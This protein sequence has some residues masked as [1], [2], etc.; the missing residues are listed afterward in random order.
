MGAKKDSIIYSNSVKNE[1][2]L[3]WAYKQGVELTTA[4]SIA[5]LYKIKKYAPGM[6]ILWRISIKEE[7]CDNLATSFSGKF[8]DDLE[9][10]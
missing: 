4:D 6:G 2:D 10:E 5:Q 7:A 9:N 3:I 8:G 1:R